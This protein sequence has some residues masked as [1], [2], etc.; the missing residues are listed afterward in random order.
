MRDRHGKSADRRKSAL[1]LEEL[2]SPVPC[3][4][5]IGKR[6]QPESLAVKV[7]G[8]GI[9]D[10]S[11]MP[12]E[13]SVKKFDEIKLS[14]ARGEDRRAGPERD[15]RP[16]AVSRRRRARLSDARPRFGLSFRRRGAAHPAG[17]ADRLAAARRALR[18]G[19]AEHRPAPAR[20]SRN[21][22]KRCSTCAISA[23]PCSSS[24]TT[25]KRSRKP[26]TSSIS[27]RW[28]ERTAAR[29]S[30]PGPRRRSERATIRSPGNICGAS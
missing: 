4:V 30:R 10:Y 11:A 21:C 20:Q 6:L 9:A 24:S 8:L 12:I 22:S 25:R 5:C 7:G 18:S 28:P 3:P 15:P 2:V 17:D 26:I 23:T 19:R 16:S 13:E 1:A 14:A 27:G 29:W